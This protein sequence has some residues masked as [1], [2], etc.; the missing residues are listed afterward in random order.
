MYELVSGQAPFT[1]RAD[2]SFDPLTVARRALSADVSFEPASDSIAETATEDDADACAAVPATAQS[3]A[4]RSLVLSLL[5]PNPLERLGC[6][7]G[8]LDIR[9]ADW[10][11][12]ERSACTSTCRFCNQ[13]KLETTASC[14]FRWPLQQYFVAHVPD[15]RSQSLACRSP[16]PLS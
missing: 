10:F 15:G 8:D 1:A 12:G 5:H 6:R 11:E 3:A 4:W 2:E 7:S 9:R 16:A 13:L 14:A